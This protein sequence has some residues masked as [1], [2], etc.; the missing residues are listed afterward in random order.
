MDG[1]GTR[2]ST[3]GNA[4]KL[5]TTP[6]LDLLARNGLYRTLKAHGTYVGLPSDA[7]MGNSEV[8]HNALGAGRVFDQGAKLVQN[9]IDSKRIY[10]GETWRDV[11]GQVTK[12][13]STL[14]FLGLLSD[15]NV[16][17]HEQHLYSLLRQAVKDGATKIRVHAL[18]DGRDVSEKS[19]EIYIERLEKVMGE[20]RALGCDIAAASGGGRMTTTM[21]RYG[22]DWKMVER[23]WYA[24][25]LGEADLRFPSLT[26]AIQH[27][28]QDQD[29]S[30]QYIPTFVIDDGGKRFEG[31]KDGDAV[32]FFNFRGDRSIEISRAFEE[33]EL[34][35]FDRKRL[36]K[37]LYAGM[38]EYDGD[39]HIP[40]RYLVSPPAIDD[41]LSEH[42]VHN[43]LRQFACSETQKYG[44]VTFFW[45]GNR[46]GM[47]DEKLE[48]YLEIPSD[49]IEFDLKPWMKAHEITDATIARMMSNSFDFA[50][51][52]YPNGDMVGHTGN[53]ESSIVAVSTIDLCVG[54]LL[55]AAEL[56][57]TILIFTADHG[58][59][60]EMFDTN[61][62]GPANWFELPFNTRPKPKTSHTLNPVPFYLFDPKGMNQYR[63][64][65]DLKDG[66]IANIPGTALAL[67]GLKEKDSYLPS[68]VELI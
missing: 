52:N 38:M 54:R 14:H 31:M 50:R 55:K 9:A 48:E 7:D 12:E 43:G 49:N 45:N 66:S 44:H 27:F 41:T 39:L 53:L 34:K 36:P 17:S 2:D 21:D 13:K 63:L 61:K 35:E 23:G 11:L 51:I 25:V 56:S 59:C 19:A 37:I 62:E 28:R 68:L 3:Y 30:D 22:A 42:L 16:H 64:R 40:N 57:N 10:E 65:T 18:L 33:K 4:F 6:Q 24:H 67:L 46:S 15:G 47:F 60:D 5:A 29:L 26:A 8:G 1:V 58:N 20:I 32:V